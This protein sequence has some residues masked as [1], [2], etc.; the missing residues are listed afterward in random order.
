MENEIERFKQYCIYGLQQICPHDHHETIAIDAADITNLL[1]NVSDGKFVQ[2]IEN[3]C[4]RIHDEYNRGSINA[5]IIERI[6]AEAI[7]LHYSNVHTRYDAYLRYYLNHQCEMFVIY[8]ATIFMNEEIPLIIESIDTYISDNSIG[9]TLRPYPD[10]KDIHRKA[11][12]ISKNLEAV[13]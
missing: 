1:V 9:H 2:F 6:E 4:R 8:R 3:H 11:T 7:I 5:D 13:S 10:Y 12:L